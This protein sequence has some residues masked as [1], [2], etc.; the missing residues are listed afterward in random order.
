MKTKICLPRSWH[1]P[2]QPPHP[3]ESFYS[4]E[5]EKLLFINYISREFD[6]ES[7]SNYFS[8]IFTKSYLYIF[9]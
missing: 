6:S 7:E 8:R 4:I 5:I 9:N 3:G 1:Q 2:K